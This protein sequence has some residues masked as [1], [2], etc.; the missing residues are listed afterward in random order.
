VF[1]ISVI[2]RDPLFQSAGIVN[3]ATFVSGIVPGSLTTIFG[4][5]LAE[6]VAGTVSTGGATTFAGTTVKFGGVA[7]PLLSITNQNGMEQINLQVPF[8]L[9]TGQTTNVEINNNGSALAVGGVPVFSAQPGIFEVPLGGGATGGAVTDALSFQLITPNN[10]AEE[11]QP[12]ALFYTGGGAITP[13]VGTGVP[14]PAPAAETT[15][16]ALVTVDG[17]QAQVLF[18]GYAPGFFGLFQI[19]FIVPEDVNC[20]TRSLVVRIGDSGSPV[21]TINLACP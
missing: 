3:A 19:N 2:G 21:S 10:P 17:R 18:S 15:L 9:P 6:G 7:A 13:E 4:V 11:G 12:L 16:P 20:G 8:G 14:G 5:G 1:P